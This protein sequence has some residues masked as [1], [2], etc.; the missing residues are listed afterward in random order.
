[1]NDAPI[2]CAHCVDVLFPNCE[3]QFD[4]LGI[5]HRVAERV[6]ELLWRIKTHVRGVGASQHPWT[7]LKGFWRGLPISRFAHAGLFPVVKGK[8]KWIAESGQRSFSGVRLGT[9][10]CKFVSLSWSECSPLPGKRLREIAKVSSLPEPQKA[11]KKVS[12]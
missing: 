12:K 11:T 5:V 7:G 6:T 3:Q 1:M 2:Y 4:I 9:L 10:Q 8:A